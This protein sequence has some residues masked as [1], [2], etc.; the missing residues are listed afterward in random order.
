MNRWLLS[1]FGAEAVE[2][3]GFALVI[4]GLIAE[5]L[6]I[7]DGQTIGFFSE[8]TNKI[9]T[10]IATFAIAV[11]VWFE[12][13]GNK[14]ISDKKDALLSTLRQQATNA[15]GHILK[16]QTL[17]RLSKETADALV[18]LLKSKLFQ[19]DPKPVLRVGSVADAEA[20]MY[21]MDFQRLF[22]SCGVNIYPTN[23]GLPNEIVQLEPN[24][25]GLIMSVKSISRPTE[26][27]A[28]FQ[29]LMHSLGLPLRVEEVMAL[30]DNE[31]VLIVLRKPD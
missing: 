8:H 14:E 5:G 12:Y 28:Q 18:P 22:E 10:V 16:M 27:H 15:E 20:Q 29:R 7:V 9:L 3:A 21:A 2:R 13:I 6:L 26:A 4:T 25:D 17:R 30:R 24:A 19:T 23:G 1:T 11:G 31:A